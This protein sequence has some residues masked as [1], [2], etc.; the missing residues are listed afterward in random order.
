MWYCLCLILQKSSDV[1][2][3]RKGR[4]TKETPWIIRKKNLFFSLKSKTLKIQEKEPLISRY[5]P[6]RKTLPRP[7]LQMSLISVRFYEMGDRLY[8]KLSGPNIVSVSSQGNTKNYWGLRYERR[9]FFRAASRIFILLAE[10]QF[11]YKFFLL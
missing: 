10:Y 2:G 5:S 6:F 1:T 11:Y 7:S 8:P 3:K 4:T 9:R